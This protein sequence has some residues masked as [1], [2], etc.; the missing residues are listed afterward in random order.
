MAANL[1]LKALHAGSPQ[2]REGGCTGSAVPCTQLYMELLPVKCSVHASSGHVSERAGTACACMCSAST[3]D[4]QQTHGL[5][6]C[7]LVCV[8][9]SRS[10][11]CTHIH[12]EFPY[13]LVLVCLYCACGDAHAADKLIIPR[14]PPW[15]ETTTP[16]QLDAQEKAAFLDWRRCGHHWGNR[17]GP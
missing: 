7:S 11:A 8:V 5:Y 6:N 3:A 2:V 13:V 14:R 10:A 9:L 12:T 4:S 1:P 17:Q 16:D 15:D